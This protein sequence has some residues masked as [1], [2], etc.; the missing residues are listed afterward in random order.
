MMDFTITAKW[1]EIEIKVIKALWKKTF[2]INFMNSLP[3]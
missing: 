1:P 2:R 3:V